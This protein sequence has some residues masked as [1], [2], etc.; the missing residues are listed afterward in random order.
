MAQRRPRKWTAKAGDV[1][2][3]CYW[4][5]CGAACKKRDFDTHLCEKPR[6]SAAAMRAANAPPPA[7]VVPV[8]TAG[9]P[10]D[11]DELLQR[12]VSR[13]ALK[14]PGSIPRQHR[15]RTAELMRDLMV[16]HTGAQRAAAAGAALARQ[17]AL[18]AARLLWAAPALLLRIPM[19][20]QEA[21][22]EEA[23]AQIGAKGAERANEGSRGLGRAPDGVLGGGGRC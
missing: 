23:C 18:R 14:T 8:Q 16:A 13:L 10:P 9:V 11:F 7:A 15:V 19:V 12:A 6:L 20:A 1:C 4:V 3:A 21:N 5:S 17:G 2:S 22:L